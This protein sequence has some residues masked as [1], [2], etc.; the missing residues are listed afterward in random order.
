MRESEC[1]DIEI[2]NRM[3]NKMVSVSMDMGDFSRGSHWS[4]RASSLAGFWVR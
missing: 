3:V 2:A 4:N 1:I